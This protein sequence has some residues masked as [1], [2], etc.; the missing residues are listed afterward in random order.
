MVVM[1]RFNQP[2]RAAELLPHLRAA[3]ARHDWVEPTLTPEGL[4]HLKATDPSSIQRFNA[5]VAATRAVANATGP[6]TVRLTADWDK[7]R[8]PASPSLVV[9]ET[10]T[11]VPPES[12]V[13]VS[14][15]TTAPSPAGP[16]KPSAESS[17]VI[18]TERAFFA[19][20]FNCTRTCPADVA[21][22]LIFRTPVRTTA[23]AAAVR[24]ADV[25][26][27]G[28]PVPVVETEARGSQRRARSSS[29]RANTSR[30]KTEG[31][32]RSRRRGRSP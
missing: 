31:S 21:N 20:G 2:V 17:Y 24:A 26:V 29:T 12:W 30:S 32:I 3:F 8:F 9:L 19:D 23:Y 13:R 16:E 7:K 11:P 5:K 10:T 25:T 14:V 6:V 15:S 22:R 1:L 18:E 4:A 27:P 28:K